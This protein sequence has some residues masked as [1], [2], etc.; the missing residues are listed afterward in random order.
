MPPSAKSTGATYPTKLEREKQ[1]IREGL[2]A[3]EGDE[4]L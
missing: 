2:E 4:D 3:K 1:D